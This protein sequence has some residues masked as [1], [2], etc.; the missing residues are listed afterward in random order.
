[1]GAIQCTHHGK[2]GNKKATLGQGD[3]KGM[4][5]KTIPYKKCTT[6]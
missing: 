6:T 1:M 4:K 2:L 3:P 5:T